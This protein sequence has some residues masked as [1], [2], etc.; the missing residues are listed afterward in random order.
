[1]PIQNCDFYKTVNIFA[2]FADW[3]TTARFNHSLRA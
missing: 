3:D 2:D 1:M